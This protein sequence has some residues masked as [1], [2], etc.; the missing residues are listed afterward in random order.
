V[1]APLP[2]DRSPD[3]PW[4]QRFRAP[5]FA[6]L[7]I[8]AGD[9]RS[10]VVS[11]SQSGVFQ[12]YAIDLDTGAMR[13]LTNA[14][15]GT[16]LAY[17]AEDGR[18]LLTLEDEGGNE[19]GHWVSI[20][21]QGG[22]RTDLTPDM[23]AYSS[24]TVAADRAGTQVA[25]AITTDDGTEILVVS[26]SGASAPRR[27]GG[28]RGLVLAL[29]FSADGRTLTGLS[30]EP[31][32][33]N[34]YAAVAFD[35]A[36]GDRVAQL[37]DG[38]PSSV[39]GL[40]AEPDGSRIA[41]SSN[42]SGR[43]RPLLWDPRAG[44]RVDL[45]LDVD[46]DVEVLDWSED[47]G[48]LLLAVTDRA[49]ESLVRY[50]VEA[51][52]GRTIDL[53]GGSFGN[54][55]RLGPDGACIVVRSSGTNAR[56]IVAIEMNGTRTVARPDAAPRGTALRSVSFPSSDGTLIQA[57]VGQP[58]GPG[59]FPT[60][61]SVHGGPEAVSTDSYGPRLASWPDH[62]YAVCA[63]NYRGSTTFGRA[64]QQAIWGN[65]GHWEVEDLAATA[66]WLVDEGIAEPGG[67]VLTGGSYGGYLT[68]LG[69]GRLPNLW[70]GGVAHVAIGDWVRMYDEAADSL[71]AYQEQVFG[72][73]PDEHP[74]RY[75]IASPITYVT[76]VAAPLLV[77]QG[78]ND[79]RCPPG[80][81]RAYEEAARKGGKSIEVE[82]FEAGHIGPSIEQIIE[83]QERSLEFAHGLF[84]GASS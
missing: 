40:I 63:L 58:D 84:A 57:W 42:V 48:E 73:P 27:L 67:I 69:L 82:W 22:D 8:A 1:S 16:V 6:D 38:A 21:V 36:T 66:A 41:T 46:G 10:A 50:D 11:S 2:P 64:Y 79:S 60:V 76:D 31:T 19:V 32:G 5:L 18:S 68:L 74:E 30:S 15:A 53:D 35:V 52:S 20:P 45:P 28:M 14:D 78:S 65:V 3:A 81:F 49:E 72:G 24:W 44:E 62:G 80:Q 47:G 43:A 70:A 71:R 51:R 23:Q 33:S 61:L 29:A 7:Q 4:K 37:W 25:I 83:Q 39:Y 59:P 54:D 9:R 77:F 26:P 13:Q 75:R 55:A 17:L 12:T 34:A 56:E